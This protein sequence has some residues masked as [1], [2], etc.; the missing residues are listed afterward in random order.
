MTAAAAPKTM[1]GSVQYIRKYMSSVI[2]NRIFTLHLNNAGYF[3]WA[4][5]T[6]IYSVCVAVAAA[7][8]KV[9]KQMRSK[10]RRDMANASYG[11]LLSIVIYNLQM[12]ACTVC[13]STLTH[14][15]FC[16]L[17]PILKYG[18]TTFT[19]VCIIHKM[20]RHIGD[21]EWNILF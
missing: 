12:T 8:D 6:F 16:Y 10:K 3:Q 5:F 9:V 21:N 1:A 19:T 15:H 11:Y 7:F 14:T 13:T 17:K 18:R 2:F 4:P 20:P